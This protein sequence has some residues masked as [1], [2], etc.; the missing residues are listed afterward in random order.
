MWDIRASICLSEMQ[1]NC[2]V[3]YG[4][5][6]VG[7]RFAVFYGIN[8]MYQLVVQVVDWKERK[9]VAVCNLLHSATWKIRDLLILPSTACPHQ[10]SIKFLTCGTQHLSSWSIQSNT[11]I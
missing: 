11:L 5:R 9:V 4:V 2:S 8:S 7:E 10:Q 1:V 6:M 3:V